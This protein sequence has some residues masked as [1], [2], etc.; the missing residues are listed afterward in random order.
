M[1]EAVES[2]NNIEN[3][4][5]IKK[6]PSLLYVSLVLVGIILIMGYFT[7]FFDDPASLF[8]S[9][10]SPQTVNVNNIGQLLQ[11]NSDMTEQELKKSLTEFLKRFYFDWGHGYFDP[12]SYFAVVTQTFYN[13]H[14]LTHQQLSHI[15]K[16][17]NKKH[18]SQKSKI[19]LERNPERGK[20]KYEF[21]GVQRPV[22]FCNPF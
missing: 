3:I 13:Y 17:K 8:K 2:E 18:D 6:D 21:Y 7:L 10:T 14:N 5:L 11:Q 19:S 9:T 1:G 16:L 15:Y 4:S 22:Y 12:P 20:R